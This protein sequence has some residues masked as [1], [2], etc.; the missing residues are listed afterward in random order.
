MRAKHCGSGST[1]LVPHPS[2][3]YSAL[4]GRSERARKGV[5][6]CDELLFG[7]SEADH[8]EQAHTGSRQRRRRDVDEVKGRGQKPRNVFKDSLNSACQVGSP[9]NRLFGHHTITMNGDTL[10]IALDRLKFYSRDAV[11]TL[12]QVSCCPDV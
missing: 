11:V 5:E 2:S 4:N 10:A 3:C 7:L 6:V 8:P 12:A 1:H 9:E